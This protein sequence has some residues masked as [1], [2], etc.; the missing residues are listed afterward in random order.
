MEDKQAANITLLDLRSVSLLAD[1]FVLCTSESSRQS[2]AILEGVALDLK[3]AGH[4]P[5][6][7]PEGNPDAGW[8]LLDYGDVVIHVFDAR[9]R[10]FYRLEELWKDARVV[11]KI[12]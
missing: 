3:K 12:Q 4:M 11:L 8:I 7:P 6:Q 2:K 5:L 9:T 1:Y 10:E